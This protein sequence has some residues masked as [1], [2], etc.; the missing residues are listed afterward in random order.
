MDHSPPSLPE[1]HA[2]RTPRTNPVGP[3]QVSPLPRLQPREPPLRPIHHQHGQHHPTIRA[4]RSVINREKSGEVLRLAAVLGVLKDAPRLSGLILT[5][6]VVTSHS[7]YCV[8][9]R[10]TARGVLESAC[11]RCQSETSSRGVC[12]WPHEQNKKA[13]GKPAEKR[14]NPMLKM[15]RSLVTNL[16]KLCVYTGVQGK[17]KHIQVPGA[18]ESRSKPHCFCCRQQ[19]PKTRPSLSGVVSEDTGL[20]IKE[21]IVAM[22]KDR[23]HVG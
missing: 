10:A 2:L 16:G 8:T 22:T 6:S 9:A 11:H 18:A 4:S 5:R 23:G 15:L 12:V 21:N 17:L 13:L 20:S 7:I 19:I 1:E 3:S 14:C